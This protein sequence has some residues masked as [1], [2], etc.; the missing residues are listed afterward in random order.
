ME[1]YFFF[2]PALVHH[3]YSRFN[4]VATNT[5]DKKKTVNNLLSAV[6]CLGGVLHNPLRTLE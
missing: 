3:K 5:K 6:R 4:V 2:W 1:N